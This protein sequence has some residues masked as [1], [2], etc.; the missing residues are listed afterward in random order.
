MQLIIAVIIIFILLIIKVV[1][2]RGQG[3]FEQV[4]KGATSSGQM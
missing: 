4:G 1:H 2:G 3:D